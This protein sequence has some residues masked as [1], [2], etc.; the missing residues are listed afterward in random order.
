VLSTCPHREP[1]TTEIKPRP[2]TVLLM[3]R[4]IV[5]KKV[6][7]WERFSKDD[8]P[9]CSRSRPAEILQSFGSCVAL[10]TLQVTLTYESD[11]VLSLSARCSNSVLV[12]S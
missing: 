7:T 8:S 3:H 6:F 5:K 10:C 2:S 4:K 11:Q 12:P 1:P 9:I